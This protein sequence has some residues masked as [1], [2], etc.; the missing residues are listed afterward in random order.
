MT[1]LRPVLRVLGVLLIMF[2]STMAV[3]ALASYAT[4]D[5]VF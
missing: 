3:P 5:G 4:E 2:G 1:D